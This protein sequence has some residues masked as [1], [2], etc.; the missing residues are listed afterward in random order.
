LNLERIKAPQ[1]I[2]LHLMSVFRF[3]VFVHREAWGEVSQAT[4]IARRR[5][6]FWKD[7]DRLVRYSVGASGRMKTRGYVL[8]HALGTYGAM[9]SHQKPIEK[10]YRP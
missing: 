2:E 7:S 4:H 8:N 3:G 10:L 1:A 6:R 9:E 5:R